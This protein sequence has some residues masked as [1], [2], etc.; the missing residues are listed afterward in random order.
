MQAFGK[1]TDSISDLVGKMKII[2]TSPSS[3]SPSSSASSSASSAVISSTSGLLF[4]FNA[5]RRAEVQLE[6]RRALIKLHQHSDPNTSP[7]GI[8]QQQRGRIL[9][10]VTR[11]IFRKFMSMC[12]SENDCLTFFLFIALQLANEKQEGLSD[13]EMDAL[14]FPQVL[15]LHDLPRTPVATR[16]DAHHFE[17]RKLL[18]CEVVQLHFP[19]ESAVLQSS[20]LIPVNPVPSWL[21]GMTWKDLFV[22]AA[23]CPAY[24]PFVYDL[25]P[26]SH[27]VFSI[28]DQLPVDRNV[29]SS[30]LLTVLRNSPLKKQLTPM[31]M[32]NKRMQLLPFSPTNHAAS[33]EFTPTALSLSSNPF[34]PSN[35]IQNVQPL[36]QPFAHASSKS[37]V[38]QRIFAKLFPQRQHTV[39]PL[40]VDE[41]VLSRFL[42]IQTE[43]T[44]ELTFTTPTSLSTAY[45]QQSSSGLSQK[46]GGTTQQ[47][48]QQQAD[49][50]LITKFSRLFGNLTEYE[51]TNVAHNSGDMFFN[52]FS[53]QAA[54]NLL[55]M[56]SSFQST[57]QNW[58][59]KTRTTS[60]ANISQNPVF[61][62]NTQKRWAEWFLDS[63]PETTEFPNQQMQSL[64]IF[65]RLLLIAVVNP[66]RFRD[67]ALLAI[68]SQPLIGVERAFNTTSLPSPRIGDKL[69]A[70][71]HHLQMTPSGY[72]Y[73]GV[74]T[75]EEIVNP[76]DSIAL[77]T[78]KLF[79]A[80]QSPS[81]RVIML[82]TRSSNFLGPVEEQR[83]VRDIC[84]LGRQLKVSVTS[85][86]VSEL[87]RDAKL[88]LELP[89]KKAKVHSELWAAAWEA[90]EKYLDKHFDAGGWIVVE[91][92]Y[93]ASPLFVQLFSSWI[94][95]KFGSLRK[96][97]QNETKEKKDKENYHRILWLL[98]P[99]HNFK[100]PTS[101]LNHISDGVAG[102]AQTIMLR[103]PV[104][105][106]GVLSSSIIDCIHKVPAEK[107]IKTAK[108]YDPAVNADSVIFRQIIHLLFVL[109]SFYSLIVEY[110]CVKSKAMNCPRFK[111]PYGTHLKIIRMIV[112]VPPLTMSLFTKKA[113]QKRQR[114]AF[115]E[116]W[117]WSRLHSNLYDRIFPSLN[118]VF[119]KSVFDLLCS[120][121]IHPNSFAADSPRPVYP[122]VPN[123]TQET[124]FTG[125]PQYVHAVLRAGSRNRG[126]ANSYQGGYM[127]SPMGN[128]DSYSSVQSLVEV[129][130]HLIV[131][132]TPRLPPLIEIP[133]ERVFDTQQV[134]LST[135]WDMGTCLQLIKSFCSPDSAITQ[136]T[137]K[138][139]LITMASPA[140]HPAIVIRMCHEYSCTIPPHLFSI[141]SLTQA[142]SAVCLSEHNIPA[143]VIAM[144][145][146]ANMVNSISSKIHGFI[147]SVPTFLTPTHGESNY[148]NSESLEQS[149]TGQSQSKQP[150]S[151]NFQMS[152]S[153]LQSDDEFEF[154][155]PSPFH[156]EMSIQSNP[157]SY[158]F[159]DT[160][161]HVC[162]GEVSLDWSSQESKNLEKQN[163]ILDRHSPAF[164]LQ[165]LNGSIGV[166]QQLHAFFSFVP[167]EHRMLG[168]T[169]IPMSTASLLA[170]GD[171]A[172]RAPFVS[173]PASTACFISYLIAI[174]SEI[175]KIINRS[176]AVIASSRSSSSY[177]PNSQAA[178]APYSSNMSNIPHPLID[179]DDVSGKGSQQA[180][181]R[182]ASSRQLSNASSHLSAFSDSRLHS[183]R[184]R[185]SSNA[186]FDEP[187][188]ILYRPEHKMS[189]H[190]SQLFRRSSS[191]RVRDGGRDHQSNSSRSIFG[192]FSMTSPRQTAEDKRDGYLTKLARNGDHTFNER[193]QKEIHIA[194][195]AAESASHK[196]HS[197]LSSL[198]STYR[199]I[200]A[201][202]MADI[203]LI[204]VPTN[205]R[206]IPDIDP[207][208]VPS[209]HLRSTLSQFFANLRIFT[210]AGVSFD[211][212]NLRLVADQSNSP[213]SAQFSASA[214]TSSNSLS[215]SYTSGI[216]PPHYAKSSYTSASRLRPLE[217]ITSSHANIHVQPQTPL[218][219]RIPPSLAPLFTPVTHRS[220][221]YC[222][223]HFAK[224]MYSYNIADYG[225]YLPPMNN[226]L[227]LPTCDLPFLRICVAV[228]D[229]VGQLHL[230]NG[231]TLDEQYLQS[232]QASI[233]PMTVSSLFAPLPGICAMVHDETHLTQTTGVPDCHTMFSFNLLGNDVRPPIRFRTIAAFD[234]REHK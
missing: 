160:W 108:R 202:S 94:E 15:T 92:L 73:C 142:A 47:Q 117:I 91:G 136:L 11:C 133:S 165:Y 85:V 34:S 159:I 99:E 23:L 66:G 129:C 106:R 107:L 125:L 50:Q 41:D 49:S 100:K 154:I 162:R 156:S 25:D 22:L 158:S 163:N 68:S 24:R 201:V 2:G 46:L 52:D 90:A 43:L 114:G 28:I 189:R 86:H 191:G 155:T 121:M 179:M 184:W 152:D 170:K 218:Q 204:F 173:L 200:P 93:L 118:G 232:I 216:P 87:Y 57:Q 63:N 18:F 187:S 20:G 112:D 109:L 127:I 144:L 51:N 207:T 67:A 5:Q 141:D 226:P 171:A 146:E 196:R 104:T 4:T 231:D 126:L 12:S 123:P 192:M 102:L 124:F 193:L 64:N 139:T 194:S 210:P 111:I 168:F 143:T 95:N 59:G 78:I 83:L 19:I 223:P 96:P 81:G 219:S 147:A 13:I 17:T 32:R 82:A 212:R 190:S 175:C 120:I 137:K 157:Y 132:N 33:S 198:Q 44:K 60:S 14:L 181:Q 205:C 71:D 227:T 27:S 6:Q 208:L 228:R 69:R 167:I 48:Q 36:Y 180:F 230:L 138:S 134:G 169:T 203:V 145:R 26:H 56:M 185:R 116:N 176:L 40:D 215:S 1:Q 222:N 174:K 103:T 131:G 16:T 122:S 77:H 164:Y 148:T 39:K 98:L 209:I 29:K 140:F 149:G 150:G 213:S 178:I 182:R 89:S 229:R 80:T 217:R 220:F 211:Q 3:S 101:S 225:D 38:D 54:Q 115:I 234:Q 135:E 21:P 119:L 37:I 65:Q 214:Q 186:G 233:V 151:G 35:I 74:P 97:V 166:I 221:D 7:I 58:T 9:D 55:N 130:L 128:D 153:T 110:F 8:T 206:T 72:F 199:R 177:A 172:L 62:S 79:N 113:N 224:I 42:F 61:M 30:V 161:I 88:S 188:L 197:G 53:A 105:F 31:Q 45:A 75:L 70:S 84:K 183:Q 10:I 76:S 195:A